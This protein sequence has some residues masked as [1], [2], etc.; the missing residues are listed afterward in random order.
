MFFPSLFGVTDS[1][2]SGHL[3]PADAHVLI[4]SQTVGAGGAASI[5]FSSIPQTYRALEFRLLLR[6]S[7]SGVNLTSGNAWANLTMYL[8]GDTGNNYSW[9]LLDGYNGA[10]QANT[11][12]SNIPLQGFMP[13][14]SLA[15][16]VFGAASI[17]LTDYASTSKNTTT[18]ALSGY[19]LNYAGTSY[20]AWNNG[21][22]AFGSTA[23]YN[24][25]AVTSVTFAAAT[26]WMQYS[27]VAMYGVQ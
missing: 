27:T 14:N 18:R 26:S 11:G 24:T 7:T 20:N 5:T 16:N 8:N 15:A 10:A 17:T 22:I 1:G 3:T 12:V 9:H 23:W 19:N 6:D 13:A 2:K 25:A 21:S 4:A